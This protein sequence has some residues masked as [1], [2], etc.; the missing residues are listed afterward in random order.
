MEVLRRVRKEASVVGS[1]EAPALHQTCTDPASPYLTTYPSLCPNRDRGS[2][3]WLVTEGT[4]DPGSTNDPD[5][6]PALRDATAIARRI[7]DDQAA[8]DRARDHIRVEGM[9][10]LAIEN[11][12]GLTLE[13]DERVLGVRRPALARIAGA[14]SST[15]PVSGTLYLTDRRL[16]FVTAP[17]TTAIGL[18]EILELSAVGDR[19]LLIALPDAEGMS[20]EIDRPRL[21]RVEVSE[22]IAASR[23]TSRQG[24]GELRQSPA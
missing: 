5:V 21:F 22:A 12:T 7:D 23:L 17:A 24:A 4:S 1:T 2:Y 20:Y 8:A 14:A 18:A 16:V 13:S 10:T 9:Q 3:A 6:D 15:T 11:E 19:Q